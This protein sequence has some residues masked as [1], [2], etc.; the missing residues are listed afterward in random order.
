MALLSYSHIVR[1]RAIVA[2]HWDGA[3]DIENLMLAD[4]VALYLSWVDSL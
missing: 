4:A 3:D 2:D 1:A